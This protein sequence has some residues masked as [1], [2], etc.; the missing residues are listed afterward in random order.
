MIDLVLLAVILV[1]ALLGALRGFVGIVVGT[2]SWL[3]SGWATFQF[4]GDAGRWLADGARPSMTYY[5]GGYALTFVA[6][7]AVVG[8]TGMA[9]RSAVRATALSATDRALG[10]G[11]GTL[12]GGFFAAV[13]VLLMSF[14]PLTR[15][16]AWRQSV[17]LPVLS[18][19]VHWMRAQLPDWRM[20]QMPQ[21]DLQQMNLQQMDLGKLPAAGDNAALGNA[22]SA[23]GLQEVMS[24]VLG[25]PGTQSA[26]PGGDPTQVL[27]A[28]IDPA[29]ARPAANDPA[30]VESNGQARPP[31]Q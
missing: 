16:P 20:P 18:P 21:L 26:Q 12:R 7:M 14:T 11:L 1:S 10:F 4:G 13:L 23:S 15:E 6:T 24:K 2:L 22:L 9:I 28:N 5:L 30:R 3:L 29:Q 31:S 25:R 17:V 27:P 19:G 8:I